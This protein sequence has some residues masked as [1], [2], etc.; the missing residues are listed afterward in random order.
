MKKIVDDISNGLGLDHPHIIKVS[1]PPCT[2]SSRGSRG[3]PG[4]Q[5]KPACAGPTR[6]SKG[7]QYQQGHTFAWRGGSGLQAPAARSSLC[8]AC[9]FARLPA[10]SP[11]CLDGSLASSVWLAAGR[12]AVLPVLGGC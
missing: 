10:L 3:G 6:S 11:G 5:A 12:P 8:A 7:M 4:G 9:R 1:C 2:C